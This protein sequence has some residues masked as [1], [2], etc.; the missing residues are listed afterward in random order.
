M[1][2]WFILLVI[3]CYFLAQGFFWCGLGMLL[4]LLSYFFE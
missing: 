1:I 2:R 3:A 4:I